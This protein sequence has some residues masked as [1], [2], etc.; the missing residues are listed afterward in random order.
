LLRDI[1]IAFLYSK[2]LG[3]WEKDKLSTAFVQRRERKSYVHG[4]I[5]FGYREN[6]ISMC[7]TLTTQTRRDLDNKV[8]ARWHDE[9]H[10]NCYIT[11]HPHKIFDNR[12]SWVKGY[13]NL[14]KFNS[15]FVVSNVQK[16]L[17]EGRAPSDA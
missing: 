6:F 12:L 3:A 10:L 5:W 13:K 9:S 16:E 14:R 8:I 7:Q 4:A 2:H 17:G 15:T 1:K 11:K